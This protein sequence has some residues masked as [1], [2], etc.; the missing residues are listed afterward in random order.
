MSL[1]T[2]LTP[3]NASLIVLGASLAALVAVLAIEHLGGYAPCPLCLQQRWAYYAAIPVSA[4]AL[5]LVRKNQ[6]NWGRILMLVC[7]VAF[8]LNAAFGVY[9]AGAEWR[10]WPGPG[11]CG[12]AAG[13]SAT[14]AG[15]LLERLNEARIIRCDEAAL[16][17]AGLSLAGYNALLSAAL[18][19]IAALGARASMKGYA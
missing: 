5:V 10:W 8:I 3:Y 13:T 11:T 9:H 18:A 15:S 7:A 2:R 16:R 14:D 19:I 1:A 17:I 12:A 4:L 6:A